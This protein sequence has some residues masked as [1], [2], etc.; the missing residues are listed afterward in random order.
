MDN[1]PETGAGRNRKVTPPFV[2][3]GRGAPGYR[4]PMQPAHPSGPWPVA[5]SIA[6]SD[7]GGGAGIQA[8]LRAFSALG[9]FG[10]TAL[11]C[12]TAQNPG[13]VSA[14]GAIDPD[15]VAAQIDAVADAFPVA[16]AKTGM[17]FSAAIMDA[18]AGALVRRRIPS[19]V[20]D[21][22]MVAASGAPLLAPDGLAAM[23]GRIVPLARVVTPNLDEAALL[24]G[25]PVGAADDLRD[26]ARDLA[27]RLGVAAIVKGG[28]RPGAR[29]ANVLCDGASVEVFE[30]SRAE[31]PSPHGA[32][33][34]FSAAI[35]AG[36][37]R[38]LP[39]AAAAR[40]AVAYVETAFRGARNAGAHR[41]LDPF[42][43]WSR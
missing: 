41:L 1:E 23:T 18:V 40:E 14:V 11:T 22:V 4:R 20:V 30:A 28:H 43:A 34:T 7:S 17:L 21:P 9:V 2:L 37:A 27:R 26:V 3:G 35:A 24:L 13:G 19:V 5:L 16:A 42:A 29:I 25:R 15:L 6:G 36:L 33:C 8:D 31:G 32:G 12:V 10:A 39:L 38:G